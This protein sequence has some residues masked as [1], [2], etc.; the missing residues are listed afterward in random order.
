MKQDTKKN[1]NKIYAEKN[2][3][4]EN[5]E[6]IIWF[7]ELNSNTNLCEPCEYKDLETHNKVMTNPES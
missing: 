7:L 2:S 4:N 1:K 5:K 6:N 3:N